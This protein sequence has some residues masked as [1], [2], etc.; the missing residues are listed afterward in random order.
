MLTSPEH[1]RALRDLVLAETGSL[2]MPPDR[3]P[4]HPA[5]PLRDR[6]R[7]R[8]PGADQT[9]PPPGQADTTTW[10]PPRPNWACPCV[11]WPPVRCAE[12]AEDHPPKERGTHG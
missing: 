8:T 6:R 12:Q 3:D 7:R 9:R 11:R 10:W 5:A 2:G 4:H 1:E